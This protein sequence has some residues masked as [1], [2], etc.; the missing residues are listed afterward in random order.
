MILTTF[1]V[2]K[3]DPDKFL[4]TNNCDFL[5]DISSES[6][7]DVY[8]EVIKKWHPDLNSNPIAA[9][10]TAKLNEIR[11][12]QKE[13]E[14]IVLF[15]NRTGEAYRNTKAS[16]GLILR[17]NS[18]ETLLEYS[19]G[20]SIEILKNAVGLLVLLHDRKKAYL[21]NTLSEPVFSYVD[22]K[23]LPKGTTI[24]NTLDTEM[25]KAF[26]FNLP[27]LHKKIGSGLYEIV[28][29]E[30][31][32]T[33][34]YHSMRSIIKQYN[35][36]VDP[37]HVAWMVSSLM[38]L[39][40]L[41]KK[42][43]KISY[44]AFIIDN[45][46]VDVANHEV[47]PVAGKHYISKAGQPIEMLPAE[48]SRYSSDVSLIDAKSIRKIAFDLIGCKSTLELRRSKEI[49]KEMVDWLLLNSPMQ[50]VEEYANW[51]KVLE[52]CFGPPNFIKLSYKEK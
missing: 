39:N 29:P 34:E 50:P 9:K 28:Y 42:V 4:K 46:I 35:G 22:R 41:F 15:R 23:Y 24:F 6:E 30:G 47:I 13:Q 20:N 16:A 44:N 7:I 21:I 3:M 51:K 40:C 8:K 27:P 49:P 52:R 18:V 10:V 12:Y 32:S 45:L 26:R 11:Q 25:A 37:K 43:L 14:T 38:N 5:L 36:K 48:L 17:R 19:P 31:D 1:D 2:F 33:S